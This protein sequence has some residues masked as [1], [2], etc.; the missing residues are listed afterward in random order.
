MLVHNGIHLQPACKE[1]LYLPRSVLGRGLVSIEHRS[2]AMLLKLL[3]DFYISRLV[4]K[5]RVAIL[6]VQEEDRTH[7]WL[8]RKYCEQK[9]K[10]VRK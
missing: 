8:I 4:H 7:L 10:T 9:Y 2:E 3:E 1:R 5:R 6:K